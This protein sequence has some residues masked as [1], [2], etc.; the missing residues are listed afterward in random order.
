MGGDTA[1]REEDEPRH[2][3]NI[4]DLYAYYYLLQ[5]LCLHQ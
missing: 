3:F 1:R 4:C 5:L 2:S